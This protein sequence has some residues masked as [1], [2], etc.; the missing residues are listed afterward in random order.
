MARRYLSTRRKPPFVSLILTISLLSVAVGVF[1]LIFVLSVMN[2]FENDFRGRILSFKAPVT[3]VSS[4]GEDLS[5]RADE[6]KR[7]DL[8]IRRVV[9]FAEGEAVAQTHDGGVLGLRVRG[10]AEAPEE[11]RL[12]RYYESESFSDKS[13][14]I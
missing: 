14:V 8:R 10:I 3:I 7:L 1:A 9:P 12:G 4:N 6:W 13:I 2:G 5:A 11:S